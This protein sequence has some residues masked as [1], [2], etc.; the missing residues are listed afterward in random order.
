MSKIYPNAIRYYGGKSKEIDHILAFFPPSSSYD[1][2]CEPYGGGGSIII[3]KIPSKHEIYND[4]DSEIV[5]FFRVLRDNKSEFLLALEHTPYSREEYDDAFI[6]DPNDSDIERARKT[7]IKAQIS[8]GGVGGGFK[9]FERTVSAPRMFYR[10]IDGLHN[11]ALRFRNVTI[12]N[13]DGLK[14]MKKVDSKRTLFYLDPHYWESR[15]V[16][17][18]NMTKEQ[19]IELLDYAIACDSMIV[20]SGQHSELYDDKLKDWKCID[21]VVSNSSFKK[22]SKRVD[23]LWVK[24]N[25]T[26]CNGFGLFD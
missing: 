3:N 5:N 18:H 14:L 4:L 25:I 23:T 16:Y 20:I 19:H 1:T 21:K 15:D 22:K 17:N 24:P 26:V 13:M 8:Y 10:W 2:Y 7:A 6:Y 11:I 12:E 9:A